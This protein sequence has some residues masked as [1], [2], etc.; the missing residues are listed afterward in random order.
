MYPTNK[1]SSDKSVIWH[2][3]CDC[4]NECDVSGSHLRSG[5]TVSCGCNVIDVGRRNKKNIIGERFGRLTVLKE[6]G[7]SAGG[8]VLWLCQC[9]CGKE[10]TV[11]S[12]KL[13]N[14][15]TQSCGC[16]QR[17]RAAESH[18]INLANSHIGNFSIIKEIPNKRA[19]DGSIIWGC[20]CDFCGRHRQLSS[21]VI[22]KSI[23]YSCGCVNL[24]SKGEQKISHILELNDINFIPQYRFT[25]CINPLSGR[26]LPFDFYLPDY[27]CCIE[28][29]GI[30]HF[31]TLGWNTEER[32]QSIIYRDN[33]KSN[34]CN[35][36]DISLI[37]IP[38]T[39]FNQIDISYLKKFLLKNETK[40]E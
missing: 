1:R 17:E 36:H 14:G 16:L 20:V 7:R 29:D 40:G 5:H 25:D 4:G 35:Q 24:S 34:Y 33:L 11:V 22:L 12:S 23:P 31:Q 8:Q 15:T 37:R 28:Y 32:L 30:Q 21:T 13:I 3:K 39:D 9:D 19:S 10:T 27:N 6:A 2:C 38:Y 26:T 18:K